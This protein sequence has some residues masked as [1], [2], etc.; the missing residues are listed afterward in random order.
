MADWWNPFSYGKKKKEQ[1]GADPQFLKQY[2]WR[3]TTSGGQVAKTLEERMAGLNVGIPQ[4]VLDNRA[5]TIATP[6]R[7]QFQKYTKPAISASASARGL[8]RSTIPTAQIAQKS[9]ETEETIADKIGGLRVGNEELKRREISDAIARLQAGA[10]NEA[11]AASGTAS[12]NLGEFERQQTIRDANV[13]EANKDTSKF[14][15][16]VGQG[17]KT[18]LPIIGGVIGGP[19]GAAIG[20]AIGE[21]F[22]SATSGGAEQDEISILDELIAKAGGGGSSKD[23]A[24]QG[25]AGSIQSL[26]KALNIG[27]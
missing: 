25:G 20:G 11:G 9:Q 14:K 15:A 17:V 13:D 1:K 16:L 5:G 26:L 18:A 12:L 23:V 4:S 10:V 24:G 8:G 2:S 21:I 19:G 6:Y 7:T 22:G 27:Q 3:D